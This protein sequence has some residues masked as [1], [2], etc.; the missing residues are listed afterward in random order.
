VIRSFCAAILLAVA[1][2]AAIAAEFTPDLAS[3]PAVPRLELP[4]QQVQKA[5]AEPIKSR[6][7]QF[8][9]PVDLTLSAP[10]GLWLTRGDIASW[11]LRLHSQGALSLS[12][13][14]GELMLPA[15]SKL[16]VYDPR[17]GLTHGPF[18]PDRIAV[19][20]LWTPAVSGDELVLEIR[21]PTD[22]AGELKLGKARVFHGFRDW[23]AGGAPGAGS[24]NIDITCPQAADWATDGDSVARISI[25]GAFLCTGQMLNNVRQDQKR[26]FITANHC[27]VDGASGPAD[28]VVFYF[29][30]EGACDNGQSD[31][32]PQP[33]FQGARQLANDVQSD[34]SLLLIT[35]LRPLPPGIYFAGW[36]AKGQTP[37]SGA[38]IHHP[39]GDE[40][41][42]SFFTAPAT[43]STVNV[44]TGCPVDAW[45]LQWSS[46]T[47]EA[48]S[49]GGGLW[50]SSH[51]LVGLL[52]GGSA[53]CDNPTGFDYFARF[54][55]GWTANAGADGQLKAHLDPDG[56]C[57]ALVPGLDPSTNPGPVN[58]TLDNQLCEGAASTCTARRSSG[59]GSPGWLTVLVLVGAG[60]ARRRHPL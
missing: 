57:V 27:G 4:P 9:V 45:E 18:A 11:R 52:S 19:S 28:S 16:W 25:G 14:L 35:D 39:A 58:P 20:G 48:G 26:L 17:A 34:F 44:G 42:I 56:T 36:D 6:P 2:P 29:G 59:G 10:Q 40:K 54:D 32:V 55:R 46:G 15:G 1:A 51:H 60:I 53:S 22:S 50:S 8:A 49:S 31:A 38:A 3:L 30:Y 7:Y 13:Q 43:K 5:L 33:T 12:L 21:A 41:K 24:C 23:K 47:T 37:D